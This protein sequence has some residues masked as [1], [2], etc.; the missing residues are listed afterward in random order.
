M[1]PDIT[2]ITA[3]TVGASVMA[4]MAV[5]SGVAAY[6]T[7][8]PRIFGRHCL[9]EASGGSAVSGLHE[10]DMDPYGNR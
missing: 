1:S 7:S 3:K 6:E 9:I 2:A 8:R 4:V 10:E 5:M